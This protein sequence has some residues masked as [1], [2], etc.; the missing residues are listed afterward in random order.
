M[1]SMKRLFL[2]LAVLPALAL[3]TNTPPPPPAPKQ[4]QHQQQAQYQRQHQ[5][6][7]QQ[8]AQQ[9]AVA[10][11]SRSSSASSATGTGTATANNAGN[12]QTV[13]TER[14]APALGQ[15]SFAIQGCGVAGNAGG[16]QTGGSAFLGFGFT[17]E[18]CYDFQLAQA[19]ASLGAYKSACEVL[20]A[21]RAG[22]RAKKRGVSLPECAPPSPTPPAPTPQINVTVPPAVAPADCTAE[23]DRAFKKCVAK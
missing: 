12:A 11:D 23:V 19:Y 18:Q 7:V 20:N 22:Q 6:Q 13:V 2:I 8:Q 5:A 3:A 10:V 4:H 15:G 14:S 9:I 17:P 21:S 1:I 16:S